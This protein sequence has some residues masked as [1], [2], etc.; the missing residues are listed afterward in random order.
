MRLRYLDG[1]R[2][3]AAAVVID[4]YMIS[5]F[6]AAVNIDAPAHHAGF[7]QVVERT[8]LHLLVAG[9]FAVCIFFVLSG[10]VLSTK[11]FTKHNRGDLLASATKRYGR[12]ALPV[13]ASVM[14]AFVLIKLHAFHNVT[15]E[16][17]TGSLW[18]LRFWRSNPSFWGALYHGFAGV[19][20]SGQSD[21]FNT[22]LWTMKI[23]LM[24]SFLVIAVLLACGRWRY[25]AVVYALLGLIFFRSYYVTFVAGSALCDLF[26]W[27]AGSP[28][29]VKKLK[30]ALQK[31]WWLP[32]LLLS[33]Y[34]GS[35]PV[36]RLSGTLFAYVH[37][38]FGMPVALTAHVLGAVGL[39]LA[40]LYAQPLQK[41]LARERLARFGDVS[42]SLYLTHLFVLGTFAAVAFT[43]LR[44]RTSYGWAFLLMIGP[45]LALTWLV[46]KLFMKYIDLKAIILTNAMYGKLVKIYR[47][48]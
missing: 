5:Y 39:T 18:L 9:N 45:S 14:V 34:L 12:L 36:D 31:G 8:P 10:F 24:G 28:A 46:A 17:Q 41:F 29:L 4:H 37:L 27:Q 6:P 16:Q 47:G 33:L 42:F 43:W 15:L 1:L 25:R 3:L 38:P 21:A 19:F 22:V 35:C 23:E 2:G 32:L 44:P 20:T 11:F 13:A 48:L 7:E 30:K 26:H 40:V